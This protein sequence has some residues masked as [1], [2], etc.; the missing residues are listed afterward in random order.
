MSD[1]VDADRAPRELLLLP[2]AACAMAIL[3]ALLPAP[4]RA[5]A[6]ADKALFAIPPASGLELP[7]DW[8]LAPFE[9]NVTAAG[10]TFLVKGDYYSVVVCPRQYCS[11]DGFCYCPF[12][13]TD[14][15]AEVIAS[16]LSSASLNISEKESSQIA[17][18]STRSG[19]LFFTDKP[20]FSFLGIT[21]GGSK[22]WSKSSGFSEELAAVTLPLAI[23]SC[24]EARIV[25]LRMFSRNIISL[26]GTSLCLY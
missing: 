19:R 11:G 10:R 6:F 12:N 8:N 1:A 21:A 13:S 26:S 4:A 7:K 22:D 9:R 25:L 24:K 5:Q 14:L 15:P 3:L 17:A 20:S 16:V 18:L 2:A 23:G